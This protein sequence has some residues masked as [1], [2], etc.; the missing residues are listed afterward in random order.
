[1]IPNFQLPETV[2]CGTLHPA[3]LLAD[4]RESGSALA[5]RRRL[6]SRLI[7][8][9][10]LSQALYLVGVENH[11]MHSTGYTSMISRWDISQL[12]HDSCNCG[13]PRSKQRR[14]HETR[15]RNK[16]RATIRVFSFT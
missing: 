7:G 10:A 4:S 14:S 16:P 3:A 9:I 5:A 2:P 13:M 15:P 1:M 12:R 6:A 11:G 8:E